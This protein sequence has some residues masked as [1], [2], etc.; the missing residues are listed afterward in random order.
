MGMGVVWVGVCVCVC[1]RAWLC[2]RTCVAVCESVCGCE[3]RG[4]AS[5]GV[6][7]EGSERAEV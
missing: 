1:V 2:E 6:G 7:G 4:E 5:W 3:G